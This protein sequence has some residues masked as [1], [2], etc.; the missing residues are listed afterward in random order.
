[1][2]R[3]L[4]I[5]LLAGLAVSVGCSDEKTI[6]P[7]EVPPHPKGPPTGVNKGAGDGPGQK[8]HSSAAPRIAP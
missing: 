8:A 4:C 2:R 6:A 7:K 3:L 1:M 5:A